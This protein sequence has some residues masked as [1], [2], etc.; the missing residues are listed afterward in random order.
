LSQYGSPCAA[1]KS[2]EAASLYPSFYL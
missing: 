2:T 1:M